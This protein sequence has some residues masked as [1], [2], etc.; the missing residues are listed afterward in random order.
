M[1][2]LLAASVPLLTPDRAVVH[3]DLPYLHIIHPL[4]EVAYPPS[5]D[6]LMQLSD[7]LA[8]VLMRSLD[9]CFDALR[10][11][12]LERSKGWNLLMTS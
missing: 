9:L 7:A 11:A 2:T 4:P 8:P 12:G 10:R 5:E 3:P 1:G 6:D